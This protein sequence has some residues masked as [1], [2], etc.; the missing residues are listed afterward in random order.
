MLKKINS[1]KVQLA[2][3]HLIG[4]GDK[5]PIK[6]SDLFPEIYSNIYLCSRKK[7][8]KTSVIFTILKR[9]ITRD[10]KVLAFVSTLNRD[11][12][13]LA[14]TQYCNTKGIPFEGYTSI[15]D[16]DKTNILNEWITAEQMPIPEQKPKSLLLLEEEEPD[17]K[18]KSKYLGPEWVVIVDDNSNELQDKAISTLLKKNRHLKCKVIISSQYFNDITPQS[19][20]QLDYIILFKGH[21]KQKL[22]E[23]HRDA[24][25]SLQFDDF[26]KAYEIA[27]A[28]VFNFLYVDCINGTLRKNFNT[29]IEI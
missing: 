2:P 23:I 14:I 25:L 7:S 20:K 9:C 8:G 1:E 3:V 22:L 6:G 27:T 16:D 21:S 11:S 13:W 26:V 18:T 19:R 24:D 12:S 5:R 28:Q 17:K 29:E 15:Y 10:T 4:E